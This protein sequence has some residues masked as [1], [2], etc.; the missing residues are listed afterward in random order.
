MKK[1][2]TSLFLVAIFLVSLLSACG[3][4]PV[5]GLLSLGEKYLLEMQYTQASVQFL[6][7]IQ[8]EPQNIQAYLGGAQ[9]FMHMGRQPA[10]LA[11]LGNGIDVTENP[12]LTSARAGCEISDIEGY[13]ALAEAYAAE[14]L[15][16][17][18]LALLELV[19]QQTGDE[20]IGRKLDIL[21]ASQIVFKN[22]YIIQWEDPAFEQMI[23]KLLGRESGDIHYNDVKDIN[24]LRIWGDVLLDGS[25]RLSYSDN[26]F[27]LDGESYEKN[28]QIQSLNDLVHFS[29]LSLLNVCY[30]TNLDISALQNTEDIDC[31]RRLKSLTLVGNNLTD[32]SVLSGLYSLNH[33]T[34]TYNDIIDI[35]PLSMLIDLENLSI[36]QNRQIASSEP[37][38]GLRKLS[39]V[40]LS[41]IDTVDLTVLRACPQLS[42]L[43][44][45]G[46]INIDYSILLDFDKLD[47]LEITCDDANFQIIKQLHSLTRLRLHGQGAWNNDT[48]ERAD[49][50]SNID[51]IGA[52]SNLTDLDLL[53]PGCY[54]ITPLTSLKLQTIE[55]QLADDCDLT[56]LQNIPTLQRVTVNTSGT[57]E[58]ADS[59]LASIRALLPGVE[60]APRD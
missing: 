16:D 17:M 42:T 7:V 46:N 57:T 3:S 28:G 52:L 11:L 37:L 54:N 53:A 15:Y 34:L 20:I 24:D 51:G 22:D 2:V 12:N 55:I 58:E 18:A 29:S 38:R 21:R 5:S 48:Q 39:S 1:R 27:W 26:T 50:L 8:I 49:G 30:Q 40:S 13:L 31:L 25:Q 59:R 36:S 56:P 44:L 60:V 4:P 9:A 23:R 19:Y 32:I 6:R 45:T 41:G 14:G 35:S 43:H 33:L 10:A 47:Y